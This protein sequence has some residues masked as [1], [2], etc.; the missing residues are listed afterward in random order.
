[1]RRR[2]RAHARGGGFLPARQQQRVSLDRFGDTPLLTFSAAPYDEIRLLVKRA[3]DVAIAAAG[4]VVLSPFMA[5]GGAADPAD[6]AR[7]GHFPAGALRAE[8][9]AVSVLQVPLD[10]R[11]TPRS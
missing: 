10:V 9:P 2:R 6:F 8:R 11:R 5:V 1:M 4:L 7:A 3:T